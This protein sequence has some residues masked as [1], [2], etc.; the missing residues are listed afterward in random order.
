MLKLKLKLMIKEILK[1]TI[2][3]KGEVKNFSV[4]LFNKQKI[5]R[6]NFK[7]EHTKN[8]TNLKRDQS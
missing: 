4:D 7:F 8:K 2:L 1:M 5:N 3:S 6:I